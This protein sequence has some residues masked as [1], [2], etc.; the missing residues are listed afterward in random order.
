MWAWNTIPPS[1]GESLMT[2]LQEQIELLEQ[3]GNDAGIAAM[4]REAT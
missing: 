3:Q 4:V 2:N 1:T